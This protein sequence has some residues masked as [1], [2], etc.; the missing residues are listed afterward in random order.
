MP[1]D[2]LRAR[3]TQALEAHNGL[4]EYDGDVQCGC[5]KRFDPPDSAKQHAAHVADAVL[6]VAQPDPD[7]VAEAIYRADTE[8]YYNE[9][10]YKDMARA[11]IDAMW[12]KP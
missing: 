12:G 2:D 7:T 9:R 6:S 5:G 4:D 10:P 1:D 3:I 8:I 11:A